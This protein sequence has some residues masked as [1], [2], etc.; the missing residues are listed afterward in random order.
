MQNRY[1]MV[2][3]AVAAGLLLF[4]LINSN[5]DFCITCDTWDNYSTS[6]AKTEPNPDKCQ[7]GTIET[8]PEE[9]RCMFE[10]EYYKITSNNQISNT[11]ITIEDLQTC[12]S[13]DGVV[14]CSQP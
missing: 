11:P 6:K 9:Y 2:F 8:G 10:D 4:A 1:Y 12:I 5:S 3:M 7:F 13:L 14:W